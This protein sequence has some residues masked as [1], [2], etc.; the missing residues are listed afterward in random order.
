MMTRRRNWLGVGLIAALVALG[1]GLFEAARPRDVTEL[2]PILERSVYPVGTA[3][4][5][6]HA[7]GIVLVRNQYY[8]GGVTLTPAAGVVGS[9]IDVGWND[10]Q[11]NLTATPDWRPVETQ[12]AY[13]AANGYQ[14]WLS[15]Q[16]FQN[17]FGGLDIITAPSGFPT[18]Y[19]KVY[20]FQAL[21]PIAGTPTRTPVA[22]EVAPDYGSATFRNAYA[23]AVASMMSKFGNDPRVGGFAMQLG[24][25]GETMNVQEDQRAYKKYWFEQVV[26]CSAFTNFVLD[27]AGWYRAG[28]AKPITLALGIDACWQTSFNRDRKSNKYFL[29]KLNGAGGATPT[30]TPLYIAYRHN[31]GNPDSAA[32]MYGTPTP[33]PWGRYQPG[34]AFPDQG[35]I[36]FEPG[37]PYGFPTQVPTPDREGYADYLLL[38]AAAANADWIFLQRQWLDVVDPR[39]LDV[40]T[41]T[42]GLG[43]TDSELAWLWFREAEYGASVDGGGYAFSGVPGPFAHLARVTGAA[44]PTTYCAPNVRATAVAYGGSAPPGACSLELS[45]PAA[46]ES[47]NA[48]GYAAGSTVAIDIA[49]DWQ[50]AG[51]ADNRDYTVTLRYLD[52]NTG[53][54]VIAW[55]FASGVGAVREINKTGSGTWRSETFPMTAALNDPFGAHDLEIRV[56][57]AQAILNSLVVANAGDSALPD[58]TP[59]PTQTPTPGAT[60][61]RTRTPQPTATFVTA[62]PTRTPTATPDWPAIA[63]P[64]VT[65]VIDGALGE[66][67]GVTPVALN[68]VT[69]R[70]IQ[71]ATPPAGATPTGTPQPQSADASATLYCGRSGNLLLFAGAVRDDVFVAGQTYRAFG[72]LSIGDAVRITLDG[73]RDGLSAPGG[74]DDHDLFV[75]PGGRVL[76]FDALP[77]SV[78]VAT[79]AVTGGWNFELALD[80]GALGMGPP[81]SGDRFGLTWHVQD[82]DGGGGLEWVLD[83]RKR[84]GTIQ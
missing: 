52:N 5:G 61:T 21:T 66:W 13:A 63:C 43:P 41:Q 23:T 56:S 39:V 80:A 40:V 68:S 67:A 3:T 33:G 71:P 81:A 76:D 29:E 9:H 47:R 74:P 15:L 24:A 25:S 62:T 8:T 38:N 7:P 34:Y 82:A 37:S 17:N 57:D 84:M 14:A 75:S 36:G 12:V 79:A 11:P 50:Y 83:D 53:Q 51:A 72:S 45:S 73:A 1:V 60:A 2:P 10:I 20:D 46:R 64:A 65:A 22:T 18:V 31:G 49:D 44:T 59:T 55:R 58:D 54:I 4:P 26:A 77:I 19:Y 30:S 48:L 16:Y 35:G 32:A 27:A 69:A 70:L 42:L 6:G 78:A 28:T